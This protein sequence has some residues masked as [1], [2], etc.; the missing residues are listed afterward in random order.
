M[1]APDLP[2]RETSESLLRDA[3]PFD[4]ARD[5]SSSPKERFHVADGSRRN[6]PKRRMT[7]PIPDPISVRHIACP[8]GHLAQETTTAK[9][10]PSE[11]RDPA[12]ST[13]SRSSPPDSLPIPFPF[14]WHAVCKR[15]PG[16]LRRARSQVN[17]NATIRGKHP[18]VRTSEIV[19]PRTRTADEMVPR[20]L[21]RAMVR[22]RYR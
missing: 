4:R 11:D 22:H 6:R 3:T 14:L 7:P 15:G 13:I 2:D 1:A 20:D 10:I 9:R 19:D 5:R 8:L 18:P 21:P 17:E 12:N 16:G